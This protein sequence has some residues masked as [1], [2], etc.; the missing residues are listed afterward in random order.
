MPGAELT[1]GTTLGGCTTDQW[2]RGRCSM[3]MYLRITDASGSPGMT[4]RCGRG[5]GAKMQMHALL[6]CCV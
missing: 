3:S 4:E 1:Q 2:Q 5:D 6:L